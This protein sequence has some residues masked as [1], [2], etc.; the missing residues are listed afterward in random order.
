[1]SAARSASCACAASAEAP[2]LRTAPAALVAAAATEPGRCCVPNAQVALGCSAR[3]PPPALSSWRRTAPPTT[4]AR[5]RAAQRGGVCERLALCLLAAWR[6]PPAPAVANRASRSRAGNV[7]A[8]D[9]LSQVQRHQHTAPSAAGVRSSFCCVQVAIVCVLLLSTR[10][11][12]A[13]RARAPACP[14]RWCHERRRH[15]TS[16]IPAS[17]AARAPRARARRRRAVRRPAAAREQ[18]G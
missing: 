7:D 3:A 9:A 2:A 12:T 14:R 15:A 17:T 11:C 13:A 5:L 18:W 16:R 6:D 8:L 4:T 10:A 1:M